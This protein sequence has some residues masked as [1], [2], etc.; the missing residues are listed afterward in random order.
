MDIKNLID[1]L[2]TL[3]PEDI[4][5]IE[6]IINKEEKPDDIINYFKA[7]DFFE[8]NGIF[9]V[10]ISSRDTSGRELFYLSPVEQGFK[11]NMPDF[12]YDTLLKRLNYLKYK[13]FGKATIIFWREDL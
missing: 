1:K 6:L 7:G 4:Q 8:K 11:L 10:I 12:W 13:K 5:K 3:P 2:K 9:Y